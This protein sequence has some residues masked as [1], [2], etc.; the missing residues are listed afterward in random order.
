MQKMA[1]KAGLLFNVA[2]YLAE[3]A[4]ENVERF[5]WDDRPEKAQHDR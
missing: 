5:C 3:K 2:E 4:A 1:C